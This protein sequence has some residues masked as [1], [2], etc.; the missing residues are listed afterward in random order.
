MGNWLD[1]DTG[2]RERQRQDLFG[3]MVPNGSF[4]GRRLEPSNHL[5][6]RHEGRLARR[7]RVR[8][9]RPSK[10]APAAPPSEAA[11]PEVQC[12]FQGQTRVLQLAGEAISDSE[13]TGSA[14]RTGCRRCPRVR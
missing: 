11:A 2:F 4:E 12:H 8:A 13:L 14:E 9:S 3:V 7:Q 10:P 5:F 1:A 6:L